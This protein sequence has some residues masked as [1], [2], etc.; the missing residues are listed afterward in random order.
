MGIQVS[1]IDAK[2]QAAVLLPHQQHDSVTPG[3]LARP[4]GTRLQHLPQMVP[5]FLNHWW[6]NLSESFLKRGIISYLYGMLCRVSATQLY[7]GLMRIH[8]GTQQG[9]SG[10][11]QP[12]WGP[13]N[14]G[15]LG[16]VH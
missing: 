2:V 14:Q 16:P 10:Q 11:H 3:A 6:W 7:L 9:A 8:H 15:H 4:N 12:T 5:N 13:M 1:E